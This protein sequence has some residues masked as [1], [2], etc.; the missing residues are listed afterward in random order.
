MSPFPSF[1]GT[2]LSVSVTGPAGAPL[3]VLVHGLGMSRDSWGEVPELLADRHRVLRYDLRGHGSSGDAR[4]GGYDLDAHARDLIAVLTDVV[5]DGERA[6]LVG[7]SLGGG[8]IL[9]AEQQAAAADRTAGVVFAAS[10]GSG[11]TA[12]GLPA[13]GLPPALASGLR[14]TWFGVLRGTLTVGRRIRPVRWIADR[15]VRRIG[16]GPTAPPD[17]VDR[18]RKSFLTTRAPALSATTLASLSHD[19]VQLAPGLHV[20][21]LVLH[22]GA[23]PEVPGD[24][25]RELIDALP[26]GELVEF[27]DAG[28]M[29]PLTHPADVADQVARWTRQV[30]AA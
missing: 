7:H 18:V 10:G 30:R 8:I 19:G 4:S 12:P 25:V 22:G 5:P 27:P 2:P 3:V 15:L 29:L 23:D 24:E 14:R 21:T 13:R 11:V 17:V 20:P 16:V 1:D 6:V 26:D 9:A 28:H